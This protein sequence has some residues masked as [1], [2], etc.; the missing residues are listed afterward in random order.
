MIFILPDAKNRVSVKNNDKISVAR[1][2]LDPIKNRVSAKSVYL[3]AVY[4]EA[5]L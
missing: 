2:F 4:L 3:E 1:I 5:L